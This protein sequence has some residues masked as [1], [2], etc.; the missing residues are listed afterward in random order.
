[1]SNDV[2]QDRIQANGLDFAFL[3]A[4]TGPLVLLL[5]GF[6]DNAQTW[7]HQ[8]PALAD[9]GYRA[10][11]PYIRGYPP[12]DVPAQPFDAEDLANDAHALIGALGAD[13]AFVVGHDWGALATMSLAAAHPESVRRAV[14]IA[15]GHPRTAVQIFQSPEQ[16]HYAF[17]IWLFQV[18][19]FAE[20][21]LRS[22]DLALVEYLWRLWSTQPP[23]S[24]H[25]ARVKKTLNEPGVIEALISYYRGLV[26]I[27]RDK[28]QFFAQISQSIKVPMLVVYG[29]DD[30]LSA[31]S[32]NEA[33]FFEADYRRV[34]IPGAKHFPHRERPEELTTLVLDWL[35]GGSQNAG[36]TVAAESRA[37]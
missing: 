16:L 14:S 10:V 34:V 6:P 30:P 22:N 13:S 4:G 12:T 25:V 26:R 29:E 19:T 2:R 3:E 33:P 11:A 23:D 18:D 37:G 1:M 8:L 32:E 35:A 5:H 17:H 7:E 27:P 21:A 28:P 9:A 24:G 36:A 15:A 31:L 20:V